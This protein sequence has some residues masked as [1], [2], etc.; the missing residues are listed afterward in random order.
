M[1]ASFDPKVEPLCK[2]FKLPD[3]FHRLEQIEA[4]SVVD[5]A[6]DSFR[7]ARANY[8]KVHNEIHGTRRDYACTYSQKTHDQI[9]GQFRGLYTEVLAVQAIVY[10]FLE[11]AF[12]RIEQLESCG[13]NYRGVW[14]DGEEFL[15]GSVVTHG[16]GCWHANQRTTARPGTDPE[17]WTLMVKRGRDGRDVR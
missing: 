16:G 15:K 5:R 10:A 9:Q 1:V 14:R 7:R 3:A 13:L 6:S 2:Q 17:M 4:R 11:I 8:L 12:E